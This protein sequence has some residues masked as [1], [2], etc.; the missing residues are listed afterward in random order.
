M[1][2]TYFDIRPII[3]LVC[4]YEIFIDTGTFESFFFGSI[5]DTDKDGVEKVDVSSYYNIGGHN[6]QWKG[7]L[8]ILIPNT[9]RRPEG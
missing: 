7:L 9:S 6:F 2:D 8:K 5:L 1:S 3:L 4:F